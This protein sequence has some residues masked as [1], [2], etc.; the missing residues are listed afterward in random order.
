MT[1]RRKLLKCR[2]LIQ[3]Y[4]QGI[5]RTPCPCCWMTHPSDKG[6][7]GCRLIARERMKDHLKRGAAASFNLPFVCRCLWLCPHQ[8]VLSSGSG[9]VNVMSLYLS[10]FCVLCLLP[11]MILQSVKCPFGDWLDD[12]WVRYLSMNVSVSE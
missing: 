7:I 4:T 2:T 9:G 1:S 12:H 11:C 3:W 8:C 6:S 10:V 5:Q